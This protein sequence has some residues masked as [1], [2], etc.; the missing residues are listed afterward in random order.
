MGTT[1]ST[2]VPRMKADLR[3]MVEPRFE[4]PGE[5]YTSQVLNDEEYGV[6]SHICEHSGVFAGCDYLLKV[7]TEKSDDIKEHFL[8]S[9]TNVEQSHV[10]RYVRVEGGK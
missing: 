6:L 7:I 4:L 8:T 9:L 2:A 1:L 10:A 5:L 3:R